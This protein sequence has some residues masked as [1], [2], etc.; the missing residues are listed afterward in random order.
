MGLL[1]GRVHEGTIWGLG[2]FLIWGWL[3]G[4]KRVEI[5]QAVPIGFRHLAE[6]WSYV[7]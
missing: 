7:S 2:S 4:C 1:T 6:Y 3:D 5:P